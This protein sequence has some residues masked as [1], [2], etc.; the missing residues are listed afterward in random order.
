MAKYREVLARDVRGGWRNEGRR[1]LAR[2]DEG[3]PKYAAEGELL[4]SR[5][6][7]LNKDVGNVVEGVFSQFKEQ[8]L[9]QFRNNGWENRTAVET[10]LNSA[11]PSGKA[12]LKKF[13]RD[14]AKLDLGTE[15][16]LTRTL[17][18]EARQ[19]AEEL[20]ALDVEVKGYDGLVV[21]QGQKRDAV[22]KR[23]AAEKE[24]AR[25]VGHKDVK[26]AVKFAEELVEQSREGIIQEMARRTER[27]QEAMIAAIKDADY[28]WQ[29]Y[30]PRKRD[31]ALPYHQFGGSDLVT[32]ADT[33]YDPERGCEVFVI[34]PKAE[35]DRVIKE[36][37]ETAYQYLKD[38]FVGKLSKKIGGILV[39][40]G[41]LK[42]GGLSSPPLRVSSNIEALVTAEF[43]D[44]GRF[45][46]RAQS[47]TVYKHNIKN[48]F[49]EQY[50]FSFHDCYFGDGRK[51]PYPD[52]DR[53]SIHFAGI[54]PKREVG[55]SR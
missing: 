8:L 55:P 24:E 41:D 43:E 27:H 17:V 38:E 47:V 11:L 21:T 10:S 2:L 12:Q 32:V 19:C 53:V 20:I 18:I 6:V 3:L 30:A 5:Y 9:E 48:G 51:L 7:E 36:R 44:G 33:E 16:E 4:K 54:K 46:V 22:V 52:L 35:R 14:S 25:R 42:E 23:Q 15:T 45:N 13:L 49:C 31:K 28:V 26:Y 40:R 50:R 29:S 1:A 34:K 37:A 39:A